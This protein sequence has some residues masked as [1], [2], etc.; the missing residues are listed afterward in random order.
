MSRE[1]FNKIVAKL[2]RLDEYLKYLS[3]IRKVNKK[4]FINDFHFFGAAER[5][6]QVSIEA[7]L[8]IGKLL[9]ISQG[10]RKP[11]DNSDILNVLIEHKVL[12]E[13]TA[14]RL[15]GM[16]NFRNF[17]VHEYEKVDREEVFEKLQK[18]LDDLKTFRKEVSRFLKKNF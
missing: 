14:Q 5:F 8:D 2:E 17:L 4:A 12:K 10:Y 3:E 13:A 11:E 16:A 18:K 15:A 9:I 1:I 7:I 6:L